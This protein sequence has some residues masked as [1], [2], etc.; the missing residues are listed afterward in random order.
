MKERFA[1]LKMYH[2]SREFKKDELYEANLKKFME[3][4]SQS[5]Q[6]RSQANKAKKRFT[7]PTREELIEQSKELEKRLHQ[8][9][10]LKETKREL[11]FLEQEFSMKSS[12]L[13]DDFSKS[14]SSTSD[15][16]FSKSFSFSQEEEKK[17]E[18]PLRR[19]DLN[20]QT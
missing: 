1:N 19:E 18:S 6:S 10:F 11:S 9:S 13:D 17:Q 3:I 14:F 4:S 5:R 20:T 15:Y 12:T 7:T 2:K 8:S 16:D